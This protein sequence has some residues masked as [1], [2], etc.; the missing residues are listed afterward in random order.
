MSK[1][2]VALFIENL[3]KQKDLNDKVAKAQP[4][5]N[6]WS[7]VAN[8]AGFKFSDEDL[9]AVLQKVLDRAVPAET[10][11]PEFLAAQSEL[12]MAQLDMVAGGV[13]SSGGGS[14]VSVSPRTLQKTASIGGAGGDAGAWGLH[15]KGPFSSMPGGNQSQGM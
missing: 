6:A 12:D 4:T 2:N 10:I 7:H 15:V 5:V 11:I 9:H 14:V 1:K 3:A 8:A 13:S